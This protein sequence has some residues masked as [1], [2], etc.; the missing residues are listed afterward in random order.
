MSAWTHFVSF[1]AA[2]VGSAYLL[3]SSWGTGLKFWSLVFYA[4]GFVGVFFAS[5]VYHF[6]DLGERWN[7]WLKRLDHSAIFVMISGSYV[8]LLVHYLDGDLRAWMLGAVMGVA[9][10]GIVLKLLWIDAP[11]WIGVALYLLMGWMV[12]AIAP[13]LFPRLP[14]DLLAW[15]AAGGLIYSVGAFVYA[16]GWPD[17]W[18][19]FFGHHE[20]WHL[21]VMGGAA[22]HFIG[23]AGLLAVPL[24]A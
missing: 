10:I 12:V 2:I 5:S 3:I 6:Y 18:P 22:A 21:F 16:R 1:L 20:V 4:V 13:V 11:T 9:T 8:P 23:I 17:P 19:G 7:R 15:L 24:P 14:G